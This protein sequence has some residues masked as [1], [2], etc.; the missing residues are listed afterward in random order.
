MFPTNIVEK[1]EVNSLKL[2]KPFPHVLRLS[3]ILV[4]GSQLGRIIMPYVCDLSFY[5]TVHVSFPV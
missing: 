4:K 3:S 1:N 5:G 2:S